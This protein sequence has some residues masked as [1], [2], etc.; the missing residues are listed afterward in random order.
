MS[1]GSYGGSWSTALPLP[2]D[3]AEAIRTVAAEGGER[4]LEHAVKKR[5]IRWLIQ[6]SR[7]GSTVH[8]FPLDVTEVRRLER[9][10]A[11]AQR[12]QAL[13]RLAGGVDH[14]PGAANDTEPG[15]AAR[16]SRLRRNRG[17]AERFAIQNAVLDLCSN[18]AHAVRGRG[19]IEVLTRRSSDGPDGGRRVEVRVT[20]DGIGMSPEVQEQATH[21]F[22]TTRE[23]GRGTGLGLSSVESLVESAGGFTR[24]V[25]QPGNGTTVSMYLPVTDGEAAVHADERRAPTTN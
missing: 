24:I 13:G 23:V 15:R 10:L 17:K 16:A 11:H 8:A 20:D 9:E 7:A 5:V 2:E 6:P 12:M 4:R 18:A 1:G 21:P 25:S 14:A 3:L 22:F 19:V